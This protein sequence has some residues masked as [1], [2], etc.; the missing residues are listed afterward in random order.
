MSEWAPFPQSQQQRTAQHM[1]GE[2]DPEVKSGSK[3]SPA[4]EPG[5]MGWQA[6]QT[7]VHGEAVRGSKCHDDV[8]PHSSK[9]I[10]IPQEIS[11]LLLLKM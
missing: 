9:I 4:Q 10:L 3:S 1:S 7:V 2:V 5:K 6:P 8:S 11:T